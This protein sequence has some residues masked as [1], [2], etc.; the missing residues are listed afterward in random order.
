MAKYYITTPIY[1]V[2]AKPHIGSA[3]TSIAADVLARYHRQHGDDVMFLMGTAENGSKMAQSAE[4]VGKKPQEFVDEMSLEFQKTWDTLNIARDEFSRNTSQRHK[5]AVKLFFER[6][7][8]SGKIYEAEYEGLYCIGHEA[9]M[10]EADLKEDGTCPDHGTKPELV[11]EKNWFFKLSEYQE[12]LR[13]KI[14]AGEIA[15]E[16]EARKNEM[17]AFIDQGL[18]DIAIS[19][20]NVKWAL[21]LPWDATQ[22][23]YVWLDE[24]FSYCSAIGYGKDKEQ[25]K[26]WWPADLHLVGKDITKF[27]AIIWPALLMA[28]GEEIPKKVFAHGFFTV[29]GQKMSKTKGNVVDPVA[30]V[31][32]YGSD[33]VRFFLLRD[34]SF[35]N[36]ADFSHD[37]MKER[38][39]ADLA[40]GLGNLVS[41]TLNM[42]EKYFDGKEVSL[43]SALP[44]EVLSTAI[45]A[46]RFVEEFAFSKALTNIWKLVSFADELIEQYK[47]W[48]LVKKGEVDR[49]QEVITQVVMIL[50]LI[51]DRIAPFMPESHETLTAILSAKPL[52]KPDKPLFARKD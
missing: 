50:Y 22:T 2:N 14:E 39:N 11:K 48:E 4:K 37:R 38:Y 52:K 26:K 29:D 16:P 12:V 45:Q 41:R 7:K 31:E 23:I 46:D 24:L 15:V 34:F 28:I 1:Y 32:E 51:N 44:E 20:Q 17:L 13:G 19:R 35:G 21:P 49:A 5:D 3:Y 27:H 47:P 40:N 6:L 25:F 18:E 36:D 33:V 43:S 10:K 8:D 9:F 42:V 30:L